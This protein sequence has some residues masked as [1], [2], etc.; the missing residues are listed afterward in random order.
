MK[1]ESNS[2]GQEGPHI[3]RYFSE[4]LKRR[5]VQ[6]IDNRLIGVSEVSRTYNVSRTAVYAWRQ[7]YSS[8]HVPE[9]RQ[10]VELESEAL[11]NKK[12]REQIAELE[13]LLGR[14]QL[15]IEV[16]EA[17]IEQGSD[18]LGIDIKKKFGMPS[19]NSSANSADA[20]AR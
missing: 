2:T 12:L 17:V 20:E 6:Q 10:V 18:S 19:S 4:E 16:L 3:Q 1:K 13:R 8:T 7:K 5:L 9:V 14:K 11:A 15:V